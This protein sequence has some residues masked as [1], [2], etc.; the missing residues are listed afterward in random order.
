MHQ[1]KGSSPPVVAAGPDGLTETDSTPGI[2]RELAF[3]TDRAVVIRGRV[4][5]GV[6][7]G[8]HHHGD[9]DAFGYVI[10]GRV[11][12]DFGASGGESTDVEAGAFFHV[13]RGIV[14]RD[15]NPTDD[16]QEIVVAFVGEGPLVVN[17]D[18]PDP[19]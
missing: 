10:R 13:P 6:T 4:E 1:E 14:H 2:V 8:W 3:A 17:V 18:G 16:R 11:R 12:F 7:S 9:R 5:G 15:A 19:G